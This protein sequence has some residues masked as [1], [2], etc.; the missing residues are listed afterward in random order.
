MLFFFFL[1]IRR[2][3]RSTLTDT[4]FPD[5]TLFRSALHKRD[6]GARCGG[7]AERD[8]AYQRDRPVADE[9]ERVGLERLAV[10]DKAAD[11]LACAEAEIEEHDDPEQIG[12]AHV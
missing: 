11:D 4:L 5:T 8:E 10:G 2:P 9:I 1:M 7:P 6:P 12:R 3:P